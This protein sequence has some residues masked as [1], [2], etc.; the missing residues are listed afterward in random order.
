[1]TG[2][3]AGPEAGAVAFVRSVFTLKF[4]HGEA[5]KNRAWWAPFAVSLVLPLLVSDAVFGVNIFVVFVML[6]VRRAKK[7]LKQMG[8]VVLLLHAGMLASDAGSVV[9]AGFI[10]ERFALE[11]DAGRM[12]VFAAGM[13]V[14]FGIAAHA[15]RGIDRDAARVG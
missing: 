12:L 9:F 14:G 8:L 10:P 3:P 13:A 4:E 5:R 7:M 1:M 15:Q 2:S 11:L 6:F